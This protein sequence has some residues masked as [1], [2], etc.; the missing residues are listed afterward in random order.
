MAHLTA[1]DGP[2]E[3]DSHSTIAP[4]SAPSLEPDACHD[5]EGPG[6][7]LRV[8]FRVRVPVQVSHAP[9]IA[10]IDD[11]STH[12]EAGPGDEPQIEALDVVADVLALALTVEF[13]LGPGAQP[14]SQ[15]WAGEDV[16]RGAAGRRRREAGEHRD[17]EE[18]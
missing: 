5:R 14:E 18:I 7:D 2:V 8:I 10:A 9:V 3:G 4:W 16:E 1:A 11:E 12:L 6:L 17:F 15:R 13:A